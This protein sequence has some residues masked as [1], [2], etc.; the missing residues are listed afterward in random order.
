MR[1]RGGVPI[2]VHFSLGVKA[3]FKCPL[4]FS[5]PVR[6]VLQS[7]PHIRLRSGLGTTYAEKVEQKLIFL[8]F[9][10]R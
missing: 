3:L 2:L 6:N 10:E 5:S 4:L 7:E 9:T 8:K 1:R